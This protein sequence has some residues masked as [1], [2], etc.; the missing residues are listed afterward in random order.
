MAAK[1]KK[2]KAKKSSK[3]D[4]KERRFL[5]D[6]T[7]SSKISV[8]AGMA[9]ALA[10]GA[11]V[12]GQFIREPQLPYGQY[13]VA[14]G[15]LV[16][17]AALWF[18]DSGGH[19]V[20]V[21]DAGVAIERGTELTRLPWCDMDRIA[22]ERGKLLLE[23]KEVSLSIP[24][25]PHR[26][27]TSWILKEAISRVPDAMDV[28]QSESEALPE[29]KEDDGELVKLENVQIAGRH[30]AASDKPIS[31]ER[32]ARLCPTCAQVYHRDHVPKK[33]VT[34]GDTIAESAYEI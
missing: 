14:G 6:A 3:R 12:Y 18:S 32:D 10:L 17:G 19:P 2:L 7:R 21:G 1:K 30:C 27:A 13:L 20:R 8:G 24:V 34:C 25:E 9:G 26:I 15:A 16:L 29:P 5:P 4:K 22:I 33:C 23:G 28:K 11:G 31:F